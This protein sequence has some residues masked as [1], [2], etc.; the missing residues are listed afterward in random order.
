[1]GYVHTLP[2]SFW[3]AMVLLTIASAFLWTSSRDHQG[4]LALQTCLFISI[5]WLTPLLLGST[6]TGTR[7]TFSLHTVTQYILRYGH[8]D[9]ASQWYHNWPAFSLL[10]AA[11]LELAGIKNADTLLIWAVV[12][13]Q[14]LSVLMLY[15]FLRRA[16]GLG[17]HCWAAVWFY[18]LFNW[19]GQ[20][21]FSPQGLGNILL[22]TLLFLLAMGVTERS[23]GPSLR[24]VGVVAIVGLTITHAL[25]SLAGLFVV[26]ALG[27]RKRQLPVL[28]MLFAVLIAA[29]LVY[30]ATVW[31]DSQVLPFAERAMRF[32]RLWFWNMAR[33]F[34][35]SEGHATVASIRIWFS[36]AAGVIALSGLA[37]SLRIRAPGD[38]AVLAMAAGIIFMAPFQFY[39]SELFIRLFL[40]IIP[41]L[42]YFAVSLLRARVTALVLV[43]L[44]LVALPFGVIALHGNAPIDYVSPSQRAYWRFLEDKTDR[45]NLGF[46]GMPIVWTFGYADRYVSGYDWIAAFKSEWLDRMVGRAWVQADMPNYLGFTGYEEGGFRMWTDFPEGKSELL[47]QVNE[48]SDHILIY[49]NGEVTSFYHNGVKQPYYE[50]QGRRCSYEV[51]LT[52][53]ED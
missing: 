1:M 28:A 30:E 50:W 20:T 4:L 25:T 26:A 15:A 7:Y 22:L 40:F 18:M 27:L 47:A 8:L 45:G 44:L 32:E 5:F 24:L 29:W 9:P 19:T 6:L 16:L 11:V 12:P 34:Q 37:L 38:R 2:L 23:G 17:N 49:D 39:E 42:A 53:W 21:Y 35:G 46:G 33:P 36:L 51:T 41:M 52:C 3:A 43:L 14:F 10:E 13:M 31:F 48:M